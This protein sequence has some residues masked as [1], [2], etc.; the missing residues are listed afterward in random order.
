[1]RPKF[2]LL[3]ALL[4]PDGPSDVVI[5]GFYMVQSRKEKKEFDLRAQKADV[6]RKEDFYVLEL[7][8]SSI[9]SDRDNTSFDIE[10]SRALY[11]VADHRLQIE[12]NSQVTTPE[13]LIFK[14]NSVEFDTRRRIVRSDDDVEVFQKFHGAEKSLF[15][16]KGNGLLVDIKKGRY[17]ILRNATAQKIL[18]PGDVMRIRSRSSYYDTKKQFL[19]FSKDVSLNSV[20]YKVNGDR[21]VVEINRPTDDSTKPSKNPETPT[22]NSLRVE[23]ENESRAELRDGTRFRAKGLQFRLNDAGDIEES[24]ALG[25]AYAELPNG[26][27]LKAEKLQSIDRDGEQVILLTET[28]EIRVENKIATCEYGEYFPG[29]GD[30]V[31]NDVASINDGSQ[32]INGDKIRYSLKDDSVVVESASGQL[33]RQGLELKNK[34]SPGPR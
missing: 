17:E 10:G 16:L 8:R 30:F 1:M 5:K 2:F 34:K 27:K 25:S 6:Y 11:S 20:K 3:A 18:S 14:T 12:A 33:N 4:I 24:Y 28:V 9:R 26:A 19:V 23:S 29:R 31:L 21:L 22:I 32:I 15:D 7:P 13:N